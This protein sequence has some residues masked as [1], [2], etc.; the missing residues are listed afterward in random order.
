[1]TRDAQLFELEKIHELREPIYIYGAGL[2]AQNLAD[3]IKT[4]T[5]ISVNGFITTHESGVK[6]GGLPVSTLNSIWDKI[7]HTDTTLIV[8]NQYSREIINQISKE[9]VKL[10][11]LDGIHFVFPAYQ[12]LPEQLDSIQ[13]NDIEFIVKH[14]SSERSKRIYKQLL[15]LRQMIPGDFSYQDI[16]RTFFSM[17]NSEYGE[18]S[19]CYSTQYFEYLDLK[20]MKTIIEGGASNGSISTLLVQYLT[21]DG[22]LHSFDPQIRLMLDIN[23]KS[24][25]PRALLEAERRNQFVTI[26]AAL[27]HESGVQ[28]FNMTG[29]TTGSISDDGVEVKVI[30]LDEYCVLNNIE[31]VDFIKLDIEGAEPNCIDGALDVLTRFRPSFAISIYHGNEQVISI[32]KRLMELLPDYTF[33][34]G[35]HSNSPFL[36]T[37][38]Y[39]APGS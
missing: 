15:K 6:V 28:N 16:F 20:P 29:D 7:N 23:E 10:K 24:N 13:Q 38:L 25:Y 3:L 21:D 4:N 34:V 12:F 8:V 18:A 39:G 17:M 9:S 11:L 14:L 26:E 37:V 35:H 5:G 1:M 19:D 30:S 27:W 36:E 33:E 32:P 31:Q 2:A 22:K